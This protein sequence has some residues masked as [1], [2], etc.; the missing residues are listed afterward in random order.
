[1]QLKK[2]FIAYHSET[3]GVIIPMQEAD[4][5]GIVRGNDAFGIMIDKLSVG[6]NEQEIIESVLEQYKG[7]YEDV[8]NAVT[9][10]LEELRKIGALDE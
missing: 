2:E 10:A 7:T 4:F 5:S 8:Q 6:T 3:D 9:S 1:M